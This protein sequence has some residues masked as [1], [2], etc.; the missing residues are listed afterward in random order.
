LAKRP[1][2]KR[3]SIL[4]GEPLADG[5]IQDVLNLVNKIRLSLPNIT[6]WL[7]S[8]YTWEDIWTPYSRK[9][10]SGKKV[11]GWTIENSLR[12]DILRQCDIFVDGRYIDKLRDITLRWRGSSNQ[13]V[14]D[15]QQ[16]IKDNKVVLYTQ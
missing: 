2:I 1:Y 8:G 14:I 11:I 16:S 9:S 3:V 7:Y 13:R 6:I 15:I 12:Q 4:G 5:N 10:M